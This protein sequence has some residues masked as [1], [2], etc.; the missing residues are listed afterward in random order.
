[1][2]NILSGTICKFWL[3]KFPYSFFRINGSGNKEGSFYVE[4]AQC[5]KL[6]LVS[7]GLV[8]DKFG[9]LTSSECETISG[10]LIN[11][12]EWLQSIKILKEKNIFDGKTKC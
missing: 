10:V 3:D 6:P 11:D 8:W 7:K 12:I 5:N 1:M 9:E 2:Y 4:I